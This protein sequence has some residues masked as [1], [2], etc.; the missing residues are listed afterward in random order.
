MRMSEARIGKLAKKIG[1]EL[2]MR[3]AVKSPTGPAPIADVV[4]RVMKIDQ[5]TE[6]EIEAEARAFLARQRTL[7]PPSTGEYQA[8]FVQAKRAAA[9]RRGFKT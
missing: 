5:R 9:A 2:A 6:E 1:R 7:P 8:A 4:S 3:G